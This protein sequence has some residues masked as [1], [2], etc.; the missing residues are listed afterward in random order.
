MADDVADETCSSYF[1]AFDEAKKGFAKPAHYLERYREYFSS[2]ADK[3]IALLELG[4]FEGDSL[5]FFAKAMPE[6][7]IFGIDLR[8]CD[9]TFSSRNV[10]TYQGS[11][12]D[13]IL[14]HRILTENEFSQFDI[15]ID[16]CSHMGSLTLNSFNLLFPFL[17]PGGLYVV[18]DWGTGYW[19]SWP[20][21]K[22]FA[23]GKHLSCLPKFPQWLRGA[24]CKL[25]LRLRFLTEYFRSHHAGMPGFI[26]HLVDEVAMEDITNERGLKTN[27]PTKIDYLHIYPGIVFM[28]KSAT[29]RKAD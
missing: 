12:E 3:Q 22:K 26:K 19:P 16:D 25:P 2:F 14:I 10:K 11:Q 8:K 1:M 13:P 5:E 18:E 24:L 9:R 20:D 15:I 4:V 7:H 29:Q 17:K 28:R 6:A 27:L 21:G 23:M